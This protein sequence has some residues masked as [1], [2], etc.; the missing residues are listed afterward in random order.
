MRAHQKHE[1][2]CRLMHL[3]AAGKRICIEHSCF[4]YKAEAA[5][6]VAGMC[7]ARLRGLAY[8]LVGKL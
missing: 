8:A 4:Y 3:D 5:I 7:R 1:A 2:C 6:G